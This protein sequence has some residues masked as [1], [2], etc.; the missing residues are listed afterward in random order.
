MYTLI[1]QLRQLYEN[2]EYSQAWRTYLSN[3]SVEPQWHLYG[4]LTGWKLGEIAAASRA[5]ERAL[6]FKPKGEVLLE[7]K[8]QYGDMQR[9][10]GGLKD[11]VDKFN[12]CLGLL[13]KF[14]DSMPL[15]Y[16]P[17][18]YNLGLC[19]SGMG[20]HHK[21]MDFY[22]RALQSFENE[23]MATYQCMC[24]QNM[25]WTAIDMGEYGN[26]HEYIHTAMNMSHNPYGNDALIAYLHYRQGDYAEAARVCEKTLRSVVDGDPVPG[27]VN[28]IACVVFAEIALLQGNHEIA[29]DLAYSAIMIAMKQQDDDRCYRLAKRVYH[30]A[31]NAKR[32]VSTGINPLADQQVGGD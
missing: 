30:K 10:M 31:I 29:F 4:S 25:A 2:K 1:A 14:P 17:T 27:D 6:S 7:C 20:E 16:G 5:A 13:E 26:A 21:A 22:V 32:S 28:A 19:Y 18:L 9:R 8:F 24:I 15:L 11:A 12:D 23:H 3:Q